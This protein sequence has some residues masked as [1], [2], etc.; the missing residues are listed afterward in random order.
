[1][2]EDCN[3]EFVQTWL[4]EQRA[5]TFNKSFDAVPIHPDATFELVIGG[6]FGKG[7]T[8]E[9]YDVLNESDRVIKKAH[10][11]A[12]TANWHEYMVW[13]AARDTRWAP[14]LGRVYCISESG[15]Y[16]MM[17]RLSDI[18]PRD[19]ANVPFLPYWVNDLKPSNFGVTA[20]RTL[21]K[22]RD[23][24]VVNLGF[25]LDEAVSHKPAWSL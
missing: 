10:P 23:Y 24:A 6:K 11:R 25:D 22:V 18:E 21:V 8:R 13:N 1:M 9:V 16:L 20:D 12:L 3:S 2:K 17:E 15:R 5:A 19:Y 4:K 14:V 7:T